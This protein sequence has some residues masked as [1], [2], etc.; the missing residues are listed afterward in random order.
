MIK[1]P[2][3]LTPISHDMICYDRPVLMCVTRWRD[4]LPYHEHFNLF[5]EGLEM[6][7]SVALAS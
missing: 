2:M 1:D 7:L 5:Y 6:K 4:V 3:N